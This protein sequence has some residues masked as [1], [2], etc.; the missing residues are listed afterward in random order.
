MRYL[1][2]WLIL[3]ARYTHSKSVYRELKLLAQPVETK[4]G[5]GMSSTEPLWSVID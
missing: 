4:L 1:L 3:P 2:I 5:D